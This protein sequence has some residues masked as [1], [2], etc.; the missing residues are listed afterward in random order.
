MVV[1]LSTKTVLRYTVISERRF[2]DDNDAHLGPSKRAFEPIE[3]ASTF[4]IRDLTPAEEA[5]IRDASGRV[6]GSTGQYIPTVNKARYEALLL[7]LVGWE[8]VVNESGQ[9]V[10]Y[11]SD[12]LRAEKEAVLSRIPLSVRLEVADV[13]YQTVTV[14]QALK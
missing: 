11:P 1:A 4:L 9:E 5:Q 7:A 12:G 14:E 3:G 6:D 2:T 8:N 10:P 13:V